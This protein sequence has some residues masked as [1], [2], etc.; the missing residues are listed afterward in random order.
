MSWREGVLLSIIAHLVFVILAITAPDWLARFDFLAPRPQPAAPPQPDDQKTRFVFVQPKVDLKALKPPERAEPSDMDRQAAS[1]RQ[2]PQPQNPLPLSR[3]NTRER[4]ERSE[5]QVARGQ[6]PAPDPLAGQQTES[7][8]QAAPPAESQLRLPE[9]QSPLQVP[10]TQPPAARSGAL[11][12]AVQPGGSLGDAL[13]NLER[14]VQRDQFENAQG[15]GAFGPAIQF[16]TKGVEFGPW[17]RRFVAQV[18]RNWM[19]PYAAMSMKGHVVVTFNVHKDGS[20][21]DLQVVG[22][23]PVD[24]FNNAAFGALASSNPT[25][26]LPAEYPSDKAFFT[27]TFFYNEE[28]Q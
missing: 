5:Q 4:V 10:S 24:A 20:I 14:Y 2:Q 13:R 16:D 27:V 7:T 22:A 28:P 3:G 19:I 26:P 1:P 25:A 8:P 21:T 23:S 12:R 11:G 18:K 9:A 17:I 6:G 15:G